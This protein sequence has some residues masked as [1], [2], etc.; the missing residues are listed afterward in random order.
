M[1]SRK[2][3]DA[4]PPFPL[5]VPVADVP[6]FSL[7]D[8][9]SGDSAYAQKLFE[10][11]CT[12]GFFLLDISGQPTGDKTIK[13]VDAMFNISKNVFDLELEEKTRYAQ[14]GA[15]GNFHG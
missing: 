7:S 5:N 3:F 12:T 11:C 15:K 10:T 13:E 4:L 6:K 9:S 8:L 14:D 1:A 2:L